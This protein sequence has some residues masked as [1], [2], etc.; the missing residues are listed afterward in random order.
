MWLGD[1]KHADVRGPRASTS[2]ELIEVSV[3]ENRAS[4][5]QGKS[6]SKSTSDAQAQSAASGT[7]QQDGGDPSG[8]PDA[9]ALAKK[10]EGLTAEKLAAVGHACVLMAASKGHKYLFMGDLD[11]ACV[12][13]IATNQYKVWS[14]GPMP[15]GFASWAM[16]SDEV[17]KRISETGVPKLRPAEWNSGEICWLMDILAPFGGG[18]QMIQ[19]LR[20]GAL[21]G[22]K[23]KTLQPAP[24]G[25][26]MAV[27]EW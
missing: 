13:A 25:S 3:T 2:V 24:D 20:Q 16:V 4:R 19:E 23:I 10:V 18:E 1:H 22:K 12:P 21:S 11:W 17:D 5:R 14:R 8:T 9:E 6:S 7:A 15:V 26:G 27:V